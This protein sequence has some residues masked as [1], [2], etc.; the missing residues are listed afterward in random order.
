MLDPAP[1]FVRW[2]RTTAEVLA[3]TAKFPKATRFTLAQRVDNLAIDVLEA[4]ARAQ[5]ARG[6]AKRELLETA[7]DRLLRLRVIVRLCHAHRVLDHGGYEHLARELDE[8][9]RMLGGWL[10]RQPE[11]RP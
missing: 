5:Y 1:L 6:Q 4:L 2:E 3:R 9:G 11:A 8:A 10:A 7:D